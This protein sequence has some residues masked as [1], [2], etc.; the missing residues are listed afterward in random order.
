MR[1]GVTKDYKPK[2]RNL[3][4]SHTLG[5][6]WNWK[7][8]G[9]PKIFT[10]PQRQGISF[11]HKNTNTP[12]LISKCLFSYFTVFIFVVVLRPTQDV[13]FEFALRRSVDI[14]TKVL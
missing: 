1:V 9:D 3:H 13:S 10:I 14:C 4:A 12:R 7:K 8:G 5:G 11:F 6:S 2:V